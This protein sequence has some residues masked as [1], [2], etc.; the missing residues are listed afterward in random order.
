M[1]TNRQ[2]YTHKNTHTQTHKHTHTQTWNVRVKSREI[3]GTQSHVQLLQNITQQQKIKINANTTVCGTVMKIIICYSLETNVTEVSFHFVSAT[4]AVISSQLPALSSDSS[5][6][7]NSL[8]TMLMDT[9]QLYFPGLL[10][11]ESTDQ[12]TDLAQ[13]TGLDLK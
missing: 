9:N 11:A 8:Q 7:Y 2:I 10:L 12:K 13:P 3:L 4:A 1:H 5:S 6:I